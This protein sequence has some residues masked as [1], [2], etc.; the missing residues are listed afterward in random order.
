M[1]AMSSPKLWRGQ[2]LQ[3]RSTERRT[4]ILDAAESL[5]GEGGAPAVTMRAVVRK[6]NLSP[7]YFYESFGSREEL[8]A[9][10][11]DRV[12]ADL[13]ARMSDLDLTGSLRATVRTVLE[14]FRAF[15]AEE[16]RRVR[17]L[18][19]EPLANDVLREHSSTKLPAFVRS[20]V[21]LL[22]THPGRELDEQS[23]AVAATALSGALVALY[24]DYVDGRLDIDADRLVEAA[25]DLVF[26]ISGI[27][28]PSATT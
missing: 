9:A 17:V 12:E 23:W 22:G 7:R 1:N 14:E 21:P 11:Y 10:V 2:S 4:E 5:L 8:L 15:F 18:L 19:R 20:M 26:A 24:V 28:D 27:A 25:V 16:P 3:D 13:L 6:A